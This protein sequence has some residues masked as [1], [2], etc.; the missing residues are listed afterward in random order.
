V[1]GLYLIRGSVLSSFAYTVGVGAALF[2]INFAE[3][4]IRG[5]CLER[6][7]LAQPAE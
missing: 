4:C 7:R 2:T 1:L 5:L 6:I 3:S